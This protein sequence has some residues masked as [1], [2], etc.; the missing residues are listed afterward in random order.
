MLK[1]FLI[2]TVLLTASALASEK[3][4]EIVSPPKS[5]AEYNK[6][7]NDSLE[8]LRHSNEKAMKNHG[9]GSYARWNIDQADGVLKFSDATRKVRLS[10]EVAVVGSYSSSSNTFLWAWANK[11]IAE[12]LSKDSRL[13][14][15]YGEKN[16][17]ND[18]IEE[19]IS[20]NEQEAWAMAALSLKVIG[21]EAVYRAPIK[22]GSLFM[23][24]KKVTPSE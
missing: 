7:L 12:K 1:S 21:G 13:V 18:L 15:E 16:K 17:L 5:N 23:V 11:S 24:I 10:C 19:K 8:A 4:P 14:K 22:T 3:P 2:V 9:I 6:L 20:G